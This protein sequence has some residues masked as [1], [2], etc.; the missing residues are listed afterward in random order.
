MVFVNRSDS[1]E[2]DRV[3]FQCRKFNPL[4]SRFENRLRKVVFPAKLNIFGITTITE[5]I[6]PKVPRI[7]DDSALNIDDSLHA[8]TI[9]I[10]SEKI[11]PDPVVKNATGRHKASLSATGAFTY[12]EI[13]V[14][15][16]DMAQ[17]K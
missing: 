4:R 2:G 8:E 15:K 11:I 9:L 13:I 1:I 7:K 10:F 16:R 14:P 17:K 12:A 6:L 3:E 5:E